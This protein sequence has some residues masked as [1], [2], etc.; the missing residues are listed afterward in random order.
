MNKNTLI[1]VTF[2]L[3]LSLAMPIRAN[4]G[5]APPALASADWSVNGAHNL[6]SNPPSLPAVEDFTGRAI[7]ESEEN[8]PVD[9]CE[10]RFADL[11]SSGDLSLIVSVDPGRGCTEL[12]IFDKA[13]TGFELYQPSAA[14]IVVAHNL[15]NSVLDINHDG[16]HELVLWAALAPFATGFSF[17]K[18]GCEAEWPLIFA[19]T[20]NGY[21]AE[22][23]DQYKDYY[24]SYLKSVEARLA[25]DS[26]ELEAASAQMANP[27][28]VVGSTRI[29][30]QTQTGMSFRPSGEA[31]ASAPQSSLSQIAAPAP[32]PEAAPIPAWAALNLAQ[33]DYPCARIEAAKTEA[34]LGIDSAS[35]MSAAIKDSESD[36]P[37]DRIVAAV[38]F[39]YL[40]TQEAEQDLKTLGNDA[41]SRVAGIAKETAS[42]GE[43]PGPSSRTIVRQVN[44]PGI[45][46]AS[47]MR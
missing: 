39:S 29:A 44:P 32:T 27:A 14:R 9:V 46:T 1:A 4:A 6:A 47:F 20:G 28:P 35:T 17:G 18:I 19:W 8:P 37:K 22:V 31:L 45:P 15:A 36:N 40:G 42:F 16:R 10:F 5:D 24:G 41:D 23:G 11:R 30:R 21:S 34:F 13:P 38:I 25:A 3:T 33:Q 2:C 26:S 43:D 12:Y 7:G